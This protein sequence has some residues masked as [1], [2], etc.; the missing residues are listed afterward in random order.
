MNIKFV[1]IFSYMFLCF[2]KVKYEEITDE[3][4][5]EIYDAVYE[6]V[7][8]HSIKC[9]LIEKIVGLKDGLPEQEIKFI[10]EKL[11]YVPMTI[12]NLKTIQ[13]TDA[14]FTQIFNSVHEDDVAQ[15]LVKFYLLEKTMRLKDELPEQ[16]IE[17]NIEKLPNVPMSKKDFKESLKKIKLTDTQ[18]VKLNDKLRDDEKGYVTRHS[19]KNYLRKETT[20]PKHNLSAEKIEFIINKLQPRQYGLN[21][22][23]V[24]EIN[25]PLKNIALTKEEFKEI[26]KK[27]KLTEA[28]LDDIYAGAKSSNANWFRSG[29]VDKK[30]TRLYLSDN[31]LEYGITT[32]EIMLKITEHFPT[33]KDNIPIEEFRELIKG[34]M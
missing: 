15:D 17:F 20:I 18:L 14:H 34:V 33:D 29:K 6:D 31:L 27:I 8:E 2:C 7:A 4:L 24:E 5:D 1:C 21:E 11:Q 23:E 30:F 3:K 26:L 16:E 25:K 9:Y 12:Q 19:V 13:L 32:Y 22:K 28:Q 10:I